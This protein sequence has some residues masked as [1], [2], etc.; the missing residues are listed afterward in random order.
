MFGKYRISV[1][2]LK[3]NVL[4]ITTQAKSPV[5]TQLVTEPIKTILLDY[6]DLSKFNIN[7]YNNLKPDEKKIMDHLLKTSGM[8][9]TLGI[10]I[11]DSELNDLIDRYE[12]LR[13]QILAGNDAKEVRKEIKTVVLKLVR[14]GK[15]PLRKSY[16]LLLELTLMD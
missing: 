15:L 12:L 13:G 1:A 8:D 5:S 7:A 16:D 2:R 14:L 9:D 10:R 3:Q 6:K 4:S 11:T